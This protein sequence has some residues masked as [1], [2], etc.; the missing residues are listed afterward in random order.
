MVVSC[1]DTAYAVGILSQYIQNPGPAHW[2]A[3]KW[4]MSYLVSTKDLWL[5]FGR[6]NGALVEGY[7]GVDWASQEG[8]HLILGL[9][10]YYRQGT[11]F[12][13]LTKQS[14][15]ALSSTKAEYITETHAAKEAIWLRSFINE[16]N[17]GI[18]WSL[19]KANNQGA[20]ALAKD[21]KFYS[22]TKHIDLHYHLIHKTVENGK[23]KMGYIL[24]ADN[25]ANIF[26]KP[27][28]KPKFKHFVKL[29]GLEIMKESGSWVLGVCE[30]NREQ[31][32]WHMH[33]HT[34]KQTQV[35]TWGRVLS[36]YAGWTHLL[37]LCA[38]HSFI[39]HFI[40]IT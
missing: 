13:S 3:L 25:V 16:V 36:I 39:S 2:E 19:M 35:F 5:T 34:T 14:I 33:M 24:S 10:F 27:L 20:M 22:W 6:K 28:A 12:W 17:G 1:P 40:L 29:L 31:V 37:F 26:T 21:N 8:H 30:N 4:V 18:I 38:Y 23:V 7:C 15:I 9:S 32:T 11:V